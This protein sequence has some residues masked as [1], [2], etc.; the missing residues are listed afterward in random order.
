MTENPTAENTKLVVEST[1]ESVHNT[2][3]GIEKISQS[4][5]PLSLIME[6]IFNIVSSILNYEVFTTSNHH[7][8][9]VST[10]IFSLIILAVGIK[11]SKHF[12][13]AIRNKLIKKSVDIH[14]ANTL[15]RISYYCFLV[16]VII[17]ALDAS[18]IPVTT[19]AII[20]TTIAV[21][22]GMGIRV[23]INNFVS[24]MILLVERPVK[25]GDFIETKS[26]GGTV[27]G[28]IKYIGARCT[29]LSTPDNRIVLIPNENL[30]QDVVINYSNK[31]DSTGLTLNLQMNDNLS[32]KQIDKKIMDILKEHPLILGSPKPCILY[33]NISNN[34]YDINVEFSFDSSDGYRNAVIISDLNRKFAEMIKK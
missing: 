7:H 27:K 11:I 30:L 29:T 2:I 20:G 15:E 28:T 8:V 3:H 1:I 21:S 12:S 25:L 34:I 17:F 10:L 24:G 16:I 33:N 23:T 14:K 32:I 22:V 5:H 31:Q 18:D 26:I 19:F 13:M 4:D 9:L 6:N